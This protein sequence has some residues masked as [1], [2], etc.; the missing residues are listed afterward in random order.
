IGVRGCPRSVR[1]VHIFPDDISFSIN[2]K[3]S[4]RVIL[5]DESISVGEPIHRALRFAEELYIGVTKG[6]IFPN[7]ILCNRVNFK[8]DCLSTVVSVLGEK[9]VVKKDDIPR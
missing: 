7:Y 3:Q 4:A 8:D 1:A 2:L 9:A 6:F 5:R